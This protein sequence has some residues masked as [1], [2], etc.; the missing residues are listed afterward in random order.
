MFMPRPPIRALWV[1]LLAIVGTVSVADVASACTTEVVA[2]APRACC[3]ERP[4]SECGCCTLGEALPSSGASS[5]ADAIVSSPANPLLR[6]SMPSCEC[7]AGEPAAPAE[8]PAQR[9]SSERSEVQGIQPF[10]ALDPAPRRP[11]SHTPL[12]LPN[13]SPPK[14]PLYLRTSRLLI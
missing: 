12:L 10:A 13:E 14:S 2:P 6:A 9:T 3:A 11:S 8:R 7:R 5:H 1:A 4:P